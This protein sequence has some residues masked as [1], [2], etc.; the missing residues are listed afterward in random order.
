M[1]GWSLGLGKY[2]GVELQLHSL[3]VLLLPITVLLSAAINGS[4]GRG[5]VLWLLLL[6][7]VLVRET[8]RGLVGAWL[9]RTVTR[10]VLL[11]TGAAPTVHDEDAT[12]SP[13]AE[14]VLSLSGP[15]ANFFAGITL[16]LLM[17]AATPHINLFERPWFTA[18]HLVRAAIWSQV[19]LGGLNLLPAWPLDSGIV[20][21]QQLVR[22]RGQA[23]A[24]AAAGISQ[25]FAT[26]LVV[27]GAFTQNVWLVIVGSSVLLSGRAQA[28]SAMASVA[29]ENIT[30]A[31]VMLTEFT[32]LQ[33]SDT[34]ADALR[35]TVHSLQDVFPVVRGTVLVGAISRE[36]LLDALR[37]DGNGYVQSAMARTVELTE[38]TAP[39]VGTLGRVR[40]T[41]GAHLLPV[42]QGE[43]I[44]G[45]VTPGN[46][47]QSMG[48]LGRTRRL[49]QASERRGGR[50]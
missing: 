30:M 3:F 9:G 35:R 33:A 10:L 38:P 43:Q 15:L 49:T 18:S 28:Q 17:Y 2:F 32:T 5:L 11:P 48:L 14:R 21:R 1:R 29:A 8:G 44:V 16:A 37:D 34:L 26:L 23:G 7:A 4:A 50:D 42:M 46:L 25:A 19:L 45:I 20:L 6:I 47:T 24:G 40:Q 31:D 41:P 27:L 39:L 36:A 13:G 22:L 12:L